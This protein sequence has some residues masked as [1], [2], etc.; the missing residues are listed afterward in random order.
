MLAR[1]RLAALFP[2][3]FLSDK[4]VWMA[5]RLTDQKKTTFTKAMNTDSIAVVGSVQMLKKNFLLL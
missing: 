4:S 3:L 1:L 2:E 5:T